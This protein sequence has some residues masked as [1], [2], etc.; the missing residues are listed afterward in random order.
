MAIIKKFRITT[1]KKEVNK[2]NVVETGI[3]NLVSMSKNIGAAICKK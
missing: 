3:L 2:I 1:F